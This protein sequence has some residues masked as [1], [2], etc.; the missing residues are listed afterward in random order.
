MF[1]CVCV[2]VVNISIT[3]ISQPKGGW[4]KFN[5]LMAVK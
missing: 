3:L 2:C 4:Y 1:V 5:I